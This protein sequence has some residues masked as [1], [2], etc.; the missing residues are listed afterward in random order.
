MKIT[1]KYNILSL[2][3]ENFK[4]N[5]EFLLINFKYVFGILI[6]L[7]IRFLIKFLCL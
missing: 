1:S 5:V 7:Y 2:G 4:E 3:V 6:I